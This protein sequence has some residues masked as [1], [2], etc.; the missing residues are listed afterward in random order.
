MKSTVSQGIIKAII[1]DL[2]QSELNEYSTLNARNED[3]WIKMDNI[4]MGY[5]GFKY[6][7]GI[8]HQILDKNNVKIVDYKSENVQWEHPMGTAHWGTVCIKV[9]KK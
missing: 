2:N 4:Y 8:V 7:M 5:A 1:N 6:E 9:D 3:G